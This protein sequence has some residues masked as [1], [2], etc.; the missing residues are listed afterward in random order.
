MSDTAETTSDIPAS[1]PSIPTNIIHVEE[2]A[3]NSF[4][5]SVTVHVNLEQQATENNSDNTQQ[6][7]VYTPQKEDAPNDEII[8]QMP[9]L[10][11]L[12]INLQS[13]NEDHFSMVSSPVSVDSP[14][15]ETP[16]PRERMTFTPTKTQQQ[17][18]ATAA[19]APQQTPMLENVET[20]S[21]AEVLDA[22]KTPTKSQQ[23][24]D[25]QALPAYLRHMQ[26]DV[27]QEYWRLH[28]KHFFILSDAGKPIFTRYGNENDLN[29]MMGFFLAIISFV[30]DTKD[31]IRTIVAGNIKLVFVVKGSLYLVAV[32]RTEEPASELA[33]QLEYIYAQIICILTEKVQEYL[34]KKKSFDLRNLLGGLYKFCD[35]LLLGTDN[36]LHSLIH[37]MS[38]GLSFSFRSLRCLRLPKTM[39]NMIGDLMLKHKVPKLTY[40]YI[41]LRLILVIHY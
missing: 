33:T 3:T 27:S 14:A 37:S 21:V 30:Q 25:R 2:H 4:M 23:Q 26:E 15:L 31:T 29:T 16:L 7:T 12:R 36:V 1:T 13:S 38:G 8:A 32:S 34:K 39:R 20:V 17:Q 5:T 35:K 6:P 10:K 18:H 19:D 28:S 40:A 22:V 41:F 9:E 24:E 11:A